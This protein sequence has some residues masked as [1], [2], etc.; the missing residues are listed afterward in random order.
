MFLKCRIVSLHVY[1]TVTCFG[2]LKYLCEMTINYC[3]SLGLLV[4]VLNSKEQEVEK[5]PNARPSNRKGKSLIMETVNDLP[6]RPVTTVEKKYFDKDVDGEN[7]SH[8]FF[9]AKGW[10]TNCFFYV[11]LIIF[12]IAN[13]QERL[14]FYCLL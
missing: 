11:F 9:I 1:G 3:T 13:R 2:H 7:F 8:H 12:F 6:D 14:C 10:T 4:P 5:R